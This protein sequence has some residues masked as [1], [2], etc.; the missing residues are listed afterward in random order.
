[1][2]RGRQ[3][4]EVESQPWGSGNGR[5]VSSMAAWAEEGDPALKFTHRPN[6]CL[7]F[8]PDAV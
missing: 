1:M 6:G 2:R 3:R 4:P 5:A 7:D 8:V